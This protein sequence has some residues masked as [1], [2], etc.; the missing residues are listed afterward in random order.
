MSSWLL[1]G[2]ISLPE[3]LSGCQQTEH[4][5][6]RATSFFLMRLIIFLFGCPTLSFG[7]LDMG[8]LFHGPLHS[9][10]ITQTPRQRECT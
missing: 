7:I 8:R 3:L 2:M 6:A 5:L 4:S 1:L 9:P 10:Y